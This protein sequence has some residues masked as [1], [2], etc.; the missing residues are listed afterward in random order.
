MDTLLSSELETTRLTD[1]EI[2]NGCGL[3]ME[4]EFYKRKPPS[5]VE[6][7]WEKN[8]TQQ[9]VA[10]EYTVS[11]QE[12]D[13]VVH[14]H[15]PWLTIGGSYWKHLDCE[16]TAARD[17]AGPIVNRGNRY[18]PPGMY[19]RDVGWLDTWDSVLVE[20]VRLILQRWSRVCCT[21]QVGEREIV[22]RLHTGE[23]KST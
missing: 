23:N 19:W 20:S 12:S 4:E 13:M 18:W 17:F 21:W 16:T 8:R 15:R 2:R 22:Y 14:S 1:A 6:L 11:T 7:H 5:N 10:F 9:S 3:T